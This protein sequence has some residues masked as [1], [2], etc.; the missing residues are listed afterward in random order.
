[1]PLKESVMIKKRFKHAG[2]SCYVGLAQNIANTIVEL[3]LEIAQTYIKIWLRQI[4]RDI[5]FRKKECMIVTLMTMMLRRAMTRTRLLWI[6]EILK[7]LNTY[8]TS[9]RRELYV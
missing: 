1:M 9:L 7:Q 2:C 3:P 8:L 4:E 5:H 6:R